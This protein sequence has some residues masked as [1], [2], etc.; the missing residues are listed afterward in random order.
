M[1]ER[2]DHLIPRGG[3]WR[4]AACRHDDG[5]VELFHPPTGARLAWIVPAEHVGRPCWVVADANMVTR[6]YTEHDAMLYAAEPRGRWDRPWP[7]RMAQFHGDRLRRPWPLLA[8]LAA[9]AAGLLVFRQAAA[10]P[11]IIAVLAGVGALDLTRA[12]LGVLPLGDPEPD[13]DNGDPGEIDDWPE[14]PRWR[15]LDDS[16]VWAPGYD[17]NTLSEFAEQDGGVSR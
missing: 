1:T 17:E 9:V 8:S 10:Y 7:W 15:A 13:H 11:T 14:D 5:T 3:R 4:I 16:V 12:V 2:A 6:W